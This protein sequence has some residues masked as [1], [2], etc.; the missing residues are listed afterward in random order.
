V[1]VDWLGLEKIV[2]SGG[3]YSAFKQKNGDFYYEFIEPSIKQLREYK[4]NSYYMETVTWIIADTGWSDIDK[5]NFQRA[6]DFNFSG[7]V[8]VVFITDSDELIDYFN[9]VGCGNRSK[10]RIT[11][12]SIFS[13]GLDSGNIPLG[14]NYDNR[15]KELDFL[16]SQ[17]LSIDPN[18]FDNPQVKFYSC[19]TGYGGKHSFAQAWVDIVKGTAW[20]FAGQSDFENIN[21]NATMNIRI[22]RKANEFSLYGSMNLPVA[23]DNAVWLEF[24]PQN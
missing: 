18:A 11:D 12:L 15:N 2:V 23:G 21:E 20:A 22:S 6:M 8:K 9:G 10:D 1:N 14:F 17:L 16:Q 13:H 19:N 24:N 5:N 3:P 7:G 4:S